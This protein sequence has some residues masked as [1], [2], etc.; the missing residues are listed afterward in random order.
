MLTPSDL[1]QWMENHAVQAELVKLPVHTLTVEA[2]AQAVNTS[3]DQIVKSLL[4]IID[5]DPVLA[6][7]CGTDH[8]D[9]RSIAGHFGVGRKRV[10]L[11][12]GETVLEVTGYPVGAVPPF[13][14]RRHL[15]TLIDP[16]VLDH[17]EVYVGGG[18]IDTLLR[19][20]PTE[21]VRLTDPTE[22]DLQR[23]ASQGS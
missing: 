19:V 11:A 13:G 15:Q 18:A 8:I 3:P 2:A 20:A 12:D 14:Q 9:R 21:I 5:G 17:E 6:I 22:L 4:F 1:A 23:P 10:K 7:A 16:K